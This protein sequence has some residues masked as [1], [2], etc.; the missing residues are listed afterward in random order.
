[1]QHSEAAIRDIKRQKPRIIL[2]ER[3][4]QGSWL[5]GCQVVCN[6]L[7]GTVC[8]VQVRMRIILDRRKINNI[9]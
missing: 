8:P 5:F 2:T 4:G 9:T 3:A 6:L 1:L 7:S